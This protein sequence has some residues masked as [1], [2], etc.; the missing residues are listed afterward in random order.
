[1]SNFHLVKLVKVSSLAARVPAVSRISFIRISIA[2]PHDDFASLN[3][4]EGIIDNINLVNWNVRREIVSTIDRPR[5]K[6]ANDLLGGAIGKLFC[7]RCLGMEW[8]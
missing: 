4:C 5:S 3:I 1:V 2:V 8:N 7:N 6:V